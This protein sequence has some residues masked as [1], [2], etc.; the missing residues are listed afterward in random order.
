[1]KKTEIGNYSCIML[2]CLLCALF[3]ITIVSCAGQ[4]DPVLITEEE[5]VI[6]EP[7]WI[8]EELELMTLR[9]K[10]AALIVVGLEDTAVNDQI[11]QKWSQYPFG[12][13]IIFERNYIKDEWLK[14]FTADLRELSLP[15]HPLLV[16]IDEEGGSIS[17]LPGERFP[18]AANMAKMSEEEVFLIGGQMAGKLKGYGINVNFAPVLDVNIDPR[19]T[20]IG[21]RSFGSNPELV[22]SFGIALFKG[23]LDQGV[24]PVGKHY[25][26]HGSTLVDSHLQLPVLDKDRAE[27]LAFEMIP[28]RR[29][30]EAGLPMIMTAH[31]VVSGIDSKPATMSKEIIAMLRS[32]LGFNGVIISDD[33]EMGALTENY[34]WEEIIIET[35][36]AGV[37][38]LLIGHSDELQAEAVRILEEA[39]AEGKITEERLNSSLRR[40]ME[41][42]HLSYVTHR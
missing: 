25:P 8:A 31:L 1:L 2:V 42:Q 6:D 38:L 15:N 29:A 16:C 5:A 37:D 7:D 27:L 40:V 13:V 17:R 41:M 34:S 4:A 23:M 33:L 12:G 24:I 20:V 35:F 28:F 30:V 21:S 11:R 10:I 9:Q 39:Y 14:E 3:A 22:S 26:G 32:D 18:S 19:N 36:M